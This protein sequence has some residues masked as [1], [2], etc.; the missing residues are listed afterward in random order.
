MADTAAAAGALEPPAAG[1][2]EPPTAAAPVALRAG[3]C[4]QG[5]RK[6][7]SGV[8]NQS[9]GQLWSGLDP[10]LLTV[11]TWA[12]AAAAVAACR[13]TRAGSSLRPTARIEHC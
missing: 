3:C 11:L 2:L 8:Y 5:R 13:P 7:R 4:L 9:L 10:G 6:H 1:V 12:A